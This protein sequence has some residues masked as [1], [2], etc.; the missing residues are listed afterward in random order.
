VRKTTIYLDDADD[1]L[2]TQAAERRGTSRTDLIREA[3]RRLL[4]AEAS[5]RKPHMPL[6]HSR[7]G[8]AARR[9]DEVLGEL[10][11]GQS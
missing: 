7:K 11:F 10:G 1:L 4:N 9:V 8:D 5:S 3:I 2:L 6:G